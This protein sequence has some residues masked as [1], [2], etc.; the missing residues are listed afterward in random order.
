M[1]S[2]EDNSLYHG[3]LPKPSI[4]PSCVSLCQSK[5][6]KYRVLDLNIILAV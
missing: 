4:W 2:C 6:N 3:S 5:N 1:G